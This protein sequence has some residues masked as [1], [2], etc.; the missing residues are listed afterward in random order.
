MTR[1]V[2]VEKLAASMAAYA[3]PAWCKLALLGAVQS[4]RLEVYAASA[5]VRAFIPPYHLKPHPNA[6]LPVRKGYG[7]EEL[8]ERYG[9]KLESINPEDEET[10]WEEAWRDEPQLIASGWVMFSP[11]WDWDA[12]RVDYERFEIPTDYTELFGYDYLHAEGEPDPLL[13]YDLS[14]RGICLS[15]EGAESIAPMCDLEAIA[16]GSKSNPP[17]RK[18]GRPKRS[19]FESADEP[20]VKEMAA[21]KRSDSSVSTRKLAE[22]FAVEASGHGTLESKIKRLERRMR[23]LGF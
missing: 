19:G 2:F 8:V 4:G 15:V 1:F 16:F 20:L 11:Y 17:I 22:R 12:P 13:Y 6:D 3:P 23:T 5:E 21:M 10:V 18:I 7:V 14:F 9:I